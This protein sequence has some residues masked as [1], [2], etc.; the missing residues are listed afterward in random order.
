MPFRPHGIIL[1]IACLLLAAGQADAQQPQQAAAV[2]VVKLEPQ[3]V[4]LTSTLPGRVAPSAEA[5]VR[6]QVNGIVT[7]RLFTKG[8]HVESGDALYRFD[9]ETYEASVR[10]SRARRPGRSR[11]ERRGT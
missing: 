4:T 10:Q 8:A 11:A 7:E 2:A 3:S 5:E 9:P 1:F 6:P